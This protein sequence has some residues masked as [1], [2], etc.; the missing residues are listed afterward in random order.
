MAL[1]WNP[2][3]IL[4]LISGIVA[5]IT[6]LLTY[7]APTTRKIRS[8]F[9]IRLAIY[10]IAISVIL[11]GISVLYMNVFIAKISGILIF[12]STI[13]FSIGINYTLKE[14]YISVHLIITISVGLFLCY[15]A[16]QPG[17]VEPI[18]ENGYKSLVWVGLFGLFTDILTFLFTVLIVYWGL[19]TW[20]NAPFLIK[21]EALI[22]FVGII[23][24]SGLPSIIL[25]FRMQY[26]LF[27]NILFYIFWNIGLF[28]FIYAVLKEP[29][30]FYIL[31][32]TIY[33][34]LVKDK[35]G[36]PLFDHD[37]SK[38]GV[39]EIMFTGFINAVQIMSEEVMDIGGLVDINLEKGIL[40]LHESKLITV[41]LVASKSSKLLKDALVNF[42]IDFEQQFKRLLKKKIK[43]KTEYE[44]AYLLIDKHFS[45][46]PFT[47][48]KSKKQELL[49]SGELADIPYELE[50]KLK[51]IFTDKEEY[52][53]ILADIARS[54]PGDTEEFLKLYE[55]LKE[56]MDRLDKDDVKELDNKNG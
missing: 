14:T 28:I 21:K 42:S 4:M 1:N 50:N 2:L 41:G 9:Y 12:P 29:K 22:L 43:D 23:L 40:I 31:P 13:C 25:I 44:S 18:I 36:Y 6:A 56:E 55:E 48:I 16:F 15:F 8:L 53:A 38:L 17:A 32:F 26:H 37:W 34:I 30:L 24:A 46:F 10:F 54:P 7:I 5:L 45:N 3:V 52:E 19:K 20:K 49:L 47:L 39:S 11:D 51:T 33:R 27:S 35:E